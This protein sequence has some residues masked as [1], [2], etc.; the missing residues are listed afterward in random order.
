MTWKP[1][2]QFINYWAC[3]ICGKRILKSEMLNHIYIYH[4]VKGE[5]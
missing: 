3:R 1:N 2:G 5:I 4:T